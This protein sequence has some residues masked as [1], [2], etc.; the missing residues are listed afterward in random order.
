MVEAMEAKT[1]LSGQALLDSLISRI[2]ASPGFAGLGASVQLISKL[3]EAEDGGTREM[4]AVILRDAALTARLLRMANSSGHARGGRNISTVEQAL[5]ILGSNTVKSVALSMA[6][7][8][9]LTHSPQQKQI[10]AEIVAAFFCGQLC[11]EATRLN[12][13]RYSVQEAQVCGLMQNLGRLMMLYHLY[14]EIERSRA[15]QAEGNLSEEDAI[16]RTLGLAFTDIAAGIA[17]HWNL[18]DVLHKSLSIRKEKSGPRSANTA[19]EWQQYC[20][21]FARSVTDVLFRL[22]EAREK[23]EQRNEV[24][25]FRDALHLKDMEVQGWIDRMLEETDQI[26]GAMGFPCTVEQARLLLRKSSERVLDLLSANDSLTRESKLADGRKPVEVFQQVL[27]Q[28]HDKFGFDRSLL[29]LPDGSSGLVAVAGVGRNAAQIAARFRCQGSRADIFRVV[30][31][32]K[33]DLYIPD[34][35]AEAYVKYLPEWYAGLVGARSVMLL[36]LVS[37]GQP[38][39]LLYSDYDMARPIAPTGMAHDPELLAW[40]EQLQTVLQGQKKPGV[41]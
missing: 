32:K 30:F 27:R 23:I 35:Q 4:T 11:A 14:P 17:Q 25:F 26:L 34:T 28:Y 16:N 6:L 37:A 2:D 5:V 24:E 8:N 38:V 19:L 12:G 1:A 20:A 13:A 15:L 22:P 40:R 31:G 9:A 10:E 39:G 29:C 7:L 3:S 21:L 18:P 41:S 36:T 33:V